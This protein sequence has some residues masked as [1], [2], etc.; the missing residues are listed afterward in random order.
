MNTSKW[1]YA[2]AGT[3]LTGLVA[4][5]MAPG[6][7]RLQ[8]AQQDICC[9]EFAPG[10]DLT[11]VNWGLSGQD[12]TN[13]GALMQ[14]IADF[15]GSATQMLT[16]VQNACQGIAVDLGAV[17]TDVDVAD[18][19][20]RAKAWCSKAQQ[21]LAALTIDVEFQPPTC[22]IN[23]NIQAS[24]EAKCNIDASCQLT[25]AEIIAR[26]DP[27]KLSGI[28]TATCTGS[29]EGSANLAVNCEG[30]CHG[31]CE[32]QCLGTCS[33]TTAGGDCKGQ[34][35][36]T[37]TGQCRGT[38][39]LD[40]N[41]MVTCNGQ[42]AGQCSV[43]FEAPRCRTQLTPPDVSCNV[44]ADCQ[45]SCQASATAKAECTQ[46]TLLVAADTEIAVGTLQ[47]NLGPLLVVLQARG[48]LFVSQATAIA[49]A[50]ANLQLDASSVKAIACA[51]PA[52]SAINAAVTN[53]QASFDAAG[54]VMLAVGIQG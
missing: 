43:E 27:G 12:E 52:L 1:K 50:A 21:L 14:A 6:C 15:S 47:R 30:T 16:D 4:S 46:P 5:V 44:D 48:E 7:D 54:S 38:C 28:C 26:C 41:A 24:C 22:T 10:G 3:A 53:V 9:T 20:E 25:P 40:A 2:L 31:A 45:A 51:V 33:D 17:P 29:C 39:D 34:C 36:G 13:Y 11:K 32:G 37:C 8:Q 18:P 42:C 49:G 23:A 19:A 35:L